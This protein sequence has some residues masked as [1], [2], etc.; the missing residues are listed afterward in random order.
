MLLHG[1]S[2]SPNISV[3]RTASSS[4]SSSTA[5][6]VV[7]KKKP[8]KKKGSFK[9]LPSIDEVSTAPT[10]F[11]SS[12]GSSSSC[13]IISRNDDHHHHDDDDDL[14]DFL[15]SLEA[16]YLND[17]NGAIVKEEE[18]VLTK[19]MS[20]ERH[21]KFIVN[22]QQQQEGV[23]RAQTVTTTT[24]DFSQDNNTTNN[25]NNTL[26]AKIAKF[27]QRHKKRQHNRQSRIIKAQDDYIE[28]LKALAE[29]S[30]LA[31]AEEVVAASLSIPPTAT[32]NYSSAFDDEEEDSLGHDLIWKEVQFD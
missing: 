17:D 10:E 31:E 27:Q 20:Y 12:Y 30:S 4:P 3:Q 18:D 23:R 5:A 8:T 16:I 14:D 13:R 32:A 9:R 24:D 26:E 1:H 11:C 25:N 7:T 19:L 21:T 2:Y 15:E 6:A 29:S 28:C 22:E